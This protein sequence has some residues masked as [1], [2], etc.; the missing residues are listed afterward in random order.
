MTCMSHDSWQQSTQSCECWQDCPRDG[1][2]VTLA[3]FMAL[4]HNILLVLANRAVC[5][6]T[7]D[8]SSRAHGPD[9]GCSRTAAQVCSIAT[10]MKVW[11]R[12]W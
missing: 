4:W 10:T 2:F 11:L 1:V 7:C 8:V 3:V 5:T 9:L 6:C 12:T